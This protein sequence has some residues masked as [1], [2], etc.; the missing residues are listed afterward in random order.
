M[1][2]EDAYGVDL[3]DGYVHGDKEESCQLVLT[4]VKAR[5][6]EST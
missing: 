1:R 2:I 6:G 5:Y 4:L 3:A